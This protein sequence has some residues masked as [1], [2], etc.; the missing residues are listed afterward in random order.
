MKKIVVLGMGKVGTLVGTLLHKNFEVTGVDQKPP[1]YEYTL[2]F[3]VEIFDVSDKS[4]LQ[5][6]L[7]KYDAVVSA[8]PYFLNKRVADLALELNLHYFDLTEDV[9]TTKHIQKLSKKATKVFAPQCGLAPG[10]I[11]IIGSDLSTY[12]DRLRDIE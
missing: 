1:H 3:P 4:A 2:P 8:L 5:P 11:G 12:F 6:L 7:Q 9:D 10:F